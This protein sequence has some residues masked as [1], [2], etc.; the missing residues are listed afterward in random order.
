M[1]RGCRI[2]SAGICVLLLSGCGIFPEEEELQKTPIIQAYE[3]EP[4]KKV[5]VKKGEMKLYEKINAVCMNLGEKQ[6]TFN[7]DDMAF[8]GI[9]VN[10]GEEVAAGTLLAE[11]S[12]DSSSQLQL[13]ADR[14]GMVTFAKELE[15]GEKSVSGQI[16]VTTNSSPGYYLNAFTK[17]W[18]MFEKGQ[19]V[20]MRINGKEYT[21]TIVTAE[22]IGLSPSVRP[23][24][25]NEESE[26]YFHIEDREAYLQSSDSG[27]F[28]LL[29]AEKQDALY[30][31]KSAVTLVND[32]KIVYVEDK[33]GIRS[34]KYIETGMETDRYIEVTKGLEEGDSIIV[35]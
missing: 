17:Y 7:V 2:L 32:D 27:E 14:A 12:G 20:V 33:D 24:N 3:Q 30:I 19:Q 9:Y 6:Y 26:V 34:V 1:K 29:V 31:P 18:N 22:D 4:F 35:E 21:A 10:K 11:L 5:E 28:S 15:D 13:I 8:K 25:P 16:I 23:D